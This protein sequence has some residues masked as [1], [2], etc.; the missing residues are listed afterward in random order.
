MRFCCR[1]NLRTFF[2]LLPVYYIILLHPPRRKVGGEVVCW[3]SWEGK[4]GRTWA[5]DKFRLRLREKG[6]GGGDLY[7]HHTTL[8]AASTVD[9]KSL[10]SEIIHLAQFLPAAKKKDGNRYQIRPSRAELIFSGHF[11]TTASEQFVGTADD[12]VGF[13]H[14]NCIKLCDQPRL[15][16]FSRKLLHVSYPLSLSLYRRGDVPAVSALLPYHNIRGRYY[17]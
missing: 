11:C 1:Y 14:I 17:R 8:W 13:E 12:V 10:N 2:M 5:G 3:S 15:A 16:G 7:L 9:R 4:K 6:G